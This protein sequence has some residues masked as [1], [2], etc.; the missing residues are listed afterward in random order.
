M[1]RL[2]NVC[3][4]VYDAIIGPGSTWTNIH[5]NCVS[6]DRLW[7]DLKGKVSDLIFLYYTIQKFHSKIKIFILIF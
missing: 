2:E 3:L 1:Q 7:S 4:S 5:L 6:S